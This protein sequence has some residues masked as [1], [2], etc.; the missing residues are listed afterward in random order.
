[1]RRWRQGRLDQPHRLARPWPRGA[2]ARTRQIRTVLHPE[3]PAPDGPCRLH[4]RATAGTDGVRRSGR[5]SAGCA[6]PG[7]RDVEDDAMGT[8]P[9]ARTKED[10][11]PVAQP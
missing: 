11:R 5:L 4:P 7:S 8:R 2:A 10:E 3:Q 9:N 6:V 1:M